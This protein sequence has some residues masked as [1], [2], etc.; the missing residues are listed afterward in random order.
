[1][2]DILLLVPPDRQ[3]TRAIDT[4]LDL[5]S[6]RSAGL[7]AAVVIAIDASD[8]LSDRMIDVGFLGER[9]TDQVSETLAREHR[10]RGQALL[11]EIAGQ[12]RARAIPCRTTIETGDPGE[13]C[14]RLVETE[15]VAAAVVVTDKRSWLARILAGAQPLRPPNLSGCEVTL[16]E[17]D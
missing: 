7:V 1:M 15:G 11:A 10:I 3:V 17:E 12:A 5:A 8:R 16:V 4:A 9:I 13:V 2:S 14:R 6:A